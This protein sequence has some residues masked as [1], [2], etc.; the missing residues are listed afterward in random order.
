MQ[1][2]DYKAENDFIKITLLPAYLKT[3]PEGMYTLTVNF[4]DKTYATGQFKVVSEIDWFINNV[5]YVYDND[6]MSGTSTESMLSFS[7]MIFNYACHLMPMSALCMKKDIFN[8]E[9]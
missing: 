8:S 9:G 2:K 7:N 1:D 5:I 6:L 4:K 3:L